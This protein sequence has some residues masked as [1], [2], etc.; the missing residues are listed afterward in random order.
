MGQAPDRQVTLGAGC[1]V[2]TPSMTVNKV[3]AS[4]MKSVMM[5]A[6]QIKLGDRDIMLAGGMECMSKVPHMMYLRKPTGYGHASAI[7]AI[8]FDGLTDVYN[9]ILMGACVE[10]NISE[11]GITREAQDEYAIMSYTRAREAQAN[12]WFKDE[13]QVLTEVDRKGKETNYEED[14]ECKKF[15]PDKFPSLKPAFS[16]TGSITAANASKI[17]DGACA[18][19]LMA[20]ETAKERGLK[21]LARIL[22]YDDAAVQPIDFAIAPSKACGSLLKK[23]G[24]EMSDI[25]FHEVNEAFSAVALANI[26]LLDLDI[27]RT[28][29]HGGAVALG[30]PIGASGARII[31]SLMNVLKRNDKSIGMARDRKSVV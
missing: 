22:G 20:E 12:G 15:F 13:I 18:F 5:A 10:K 11:M 23:V 8:T 24:M 25:D 9:N 29:V 7:D 2:D 21:P 27:T 16:K 3:C 19:V 26:K 1:N 14:E 4:G 31:L 28:N 17:N 6:Q 30:H